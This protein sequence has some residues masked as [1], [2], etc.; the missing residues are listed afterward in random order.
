MQALGEAVAA[1][2]WF[3]PRAVWSAGSTCGQKWSKV[4]EKMSKSMQVHGI[5][6][7]LFF[8]VFFKALISVDV[9]VSEVAQQVA[10]YVHVVQSE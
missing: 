10:L 2:D 7:F 8:P 4:G 9:K 5:K 1:W 3:L 6:I